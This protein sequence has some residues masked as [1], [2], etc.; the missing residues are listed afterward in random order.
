VK[1]IWKT[2]HGVRWSIAKKKEGRTCFGYGGFNVFQGGVHPSYG[3][4]GESGKTRK[5]RRRHGEQSLATIDDDG[6]DDKYDD[7]WQSGNVPLK[8]TFHFP[9]PKKEKENSVTP[10]N[11]R[12]VTKAANRR[13][14]FL[15]DFCVYLC[16]CHCRC[17]SCQ[18]VKHLLPFAWQ[19]RAAPPNPL[20]GTHVP[21]PPLVAFALHPQ[22]VTCASFRYPVPVNFLTFAF[23][24]LWQEC[25]ERKVPKK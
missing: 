8:M 21:A 3:E 11:L 5:S 7:G 2:R 6:D 12:L 24:Y 4:I 1:Y 22:S 17:H 15:F 25:T 14:Y 9:C 10:K 13:A 20:F 19:M 16:R 18:S 23:T